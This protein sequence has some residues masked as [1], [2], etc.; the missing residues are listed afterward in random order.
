MSLVVR[1]ILWCMLRE[2][3]RVV[4]VLVLENSL[5]VN[6]FIELPCFSIRA[7]GE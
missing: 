3:Y 7:I 6:E 4:V 1:T 5:L 2:K